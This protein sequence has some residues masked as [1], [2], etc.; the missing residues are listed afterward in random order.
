[1]IMRICIDPGHSGKFEPGAC[2]GGNSEACIDLRIGKL[3]GKILESH[4]YDVC[5]TRTGE[6]RNDDL[7]WRAELANQ[8]GAD[9]FVS[10]HCNSSTD[11]AAHGAEVWYFPGSEQGRS[12]AEY[13]QQSVV[14][15][16]GAAD[17]GVK[18]NAEL[19]VLWAT[20]CPAVLVEMGFLSNPE[21][22]MEMTDLLLRR[23]YA[24]AIAAG[25]EAWIAAQR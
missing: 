5:Y 3:I 22:R 25:I 7:S 12:L 17:R 21:E 24:V 6:I 10:I 13:I 11:P 19:T 18:A 20:D 15:R 4:G 14:E 1:L 9:I 8:A 2:A 23:Q 16:I